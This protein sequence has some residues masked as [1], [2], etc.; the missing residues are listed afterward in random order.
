RGKGRDP[1][2][3]LTWQD[4][5]DYVGWLNRRTGGSYRLPTEAEWEY[6]ARGGTTTAY[7]WGPT[8]EPGLANC[9][10]CGGDW[11]AKDAIAAVGQFT[12]RQHPFGLHDTAG[13]VGEW[14][15]DCW[16]DK[17]TAELPDQHAWGEENGGDC[18]KRVIRGGSWSDEADYTR[19]AA[20]YWRPAVTSG[21]RVGFRLA[22]DLP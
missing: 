12:S 17:Y 16:H 18:R 4:A 20:R 8:L 5:R 6:A 22:A 2:N 21:S 3:A 1:V 7:W 19:S 11:D 9:E 15:E 14:M 10:G 13:N